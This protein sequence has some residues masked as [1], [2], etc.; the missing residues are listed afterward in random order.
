MVNYSKGRIYKIWNDVNDSIYVGSTTQRLSSRMR[1]HRHSCKNNPNMKLYQAFN[2]LGIHNFH[3]E[4]IEKY[5][6]LD[7][8]SLLAREGYYIRKFNSHK[9]G[10]NKN[11]AGRNT[12]SYYKDNQQQI[13]DNS[14]AYY[15]KHRD[16][17]NEQAKQYSKKYYILH[18]KHKKQYGKNYYL[19]NRERILARN[20]QCYQQKKQLNEHHHAPSSA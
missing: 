19:A 1:G 17:I 10:Y 12:K 5:P 6:C 14:K 16:R 3:I 18:K 8:E 9:I 15:K 4:L 2:E 20:K 11:V 13:L 7:R